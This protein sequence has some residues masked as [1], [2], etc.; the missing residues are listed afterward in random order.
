MQSP[1]YGSG[2]TNSRFQKGLFHVKQQEW[3]SSWQVGFYQQ[4]NIKGWN[5]GVDA[6]T[7]VGQDHHSALPFYNEYD[8]IRIRLGTDT[9]KERPFYLHGYRGKQCGSVRVGLKDDKCLLM[10]TGPEAERV[11][12]ISR[13]VHVKYTRIDLQVTLEME[14]PVKSWAEDIYDAPNLREA[15]ERGKI[16]TSLV[17]SPTGTTLY[18]NKRTSPTY[19]R[20][21]DK[22]E[23]YMGVLGKFWRFEV[24][25]KEDHSD[26]LG[27]IL[28]NLHEYETV[29]L[30]YVTGW[31][32]DRGICV[33][34][35]PR[36]TVR[37]PG[38]S[39]RT[40]S[41]EQTLAWLARQV[42]PSILALLSAGKGEEVERALGVQLEMPEYWNDERNSE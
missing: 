5:A 7:V 36:D 2:S 19:A 30:D 40:T 11:F 17:K 3:S 4:G 1:M 22:S 29:A 25:A 6:I 26:R 14:S 20:M 31:Y 21:Y 16:H 23:E 13:Q 42:R 38:V 15:T 37:L 35:G 24:E 27:R 39:T 18:L 8:N 33:P 28:E 9:C 32:G 12:A 41:D 34:V 10:V